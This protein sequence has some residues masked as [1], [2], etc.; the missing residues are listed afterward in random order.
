MG[1]VD[2]AEGT[3]KSTKRQIPGLARQVQ[4]QAVGKTQGRTR[5][6]QIE[7]RRND[8]GILECQVLVMEQH[9]DGRGEGN[10]VTFVGGGQDPSRLRERE[11]RNT[12]P[13]CDESVSGCGLTRIIAR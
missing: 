5:A 3:I 11:N 10:G 13:H 12:G 8:V 4:Y 9:F 1:S 6:K 7:R 2:L